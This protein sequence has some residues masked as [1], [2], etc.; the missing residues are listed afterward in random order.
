MTDGSPTEGGTGGS[1]G[2]DSTTG[3]GTTGGGTTGDTTGSDG[4]TGGTTGSDGTTGDSGDASLC[5]DA[6]D[7]LVS[8]G[9]EENVP[10][11]L[12]WCD[13]LVE[14]VSD[15]HV[16]LGCAALVEDFLECVAE[17]PMCFER[18]PCSGLDVAI[19]EQCSCGQTAGGAID[20][21][22]CTYEE[23][24]GVVSREVHCVGGTCTCEVNGED[25]GE[26][27]TQA[28]ICGSL[29]QGSDLMAIAAGE[30]CGW[31]PFELGD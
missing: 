8:C 25:V 27:Q 2:S 3:G 9:L 18:D 22:E 20:G 13:P 4:T 19:E 11:C 1:A 21:S 30:C 14:E 7:K 5:Q 10:E 12:S 16:F 26:C 28:K 17:E 6:C 29:D 23:E 15:P 24:C 31:E